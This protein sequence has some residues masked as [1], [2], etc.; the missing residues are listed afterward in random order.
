MNQGKFVELKCRF[1]FILMCRYVIELVVIRKQMQHE[2]K[3][4]ESKKQKGLQ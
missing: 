1:Y 4:N 3:N 2:N